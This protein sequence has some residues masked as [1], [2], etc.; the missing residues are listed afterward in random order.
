MLIRGESGTGK[1]LVAELIH[2]NSPRAAGPLVKV[3]CAALP[4]SLV[5]AELFGHERGAF[6]GALRA[7]RGASSSRTAARSSSTRSARCPLA[8]Q[9]KLLRV[10][11]E[12]E[13]ERVGG[14]ET[15]RVDVRLIAATNRDLERA[16]AEGTFREDLYYRLNVFTIC[17]P[18]LRERKPD[19]LLLA[20]HFVEKYAREHDKAVRRIST[21]AIDMLDELPLAGERARA[22]ELHRARGRPLRRRRPAQP[23][24]AA[25]AADARRAPG[26]VP[27][28]RCASPWPRWSAR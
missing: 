23:S 7:A 16:M 8:T 12:R 22:G 3:N 5:E 10:L 9:A 6:T 4:E 11:Q 28:A 1:E 26:T 24:P 27:P 20:D 2:R 15:L 13:F 25:Y 19:I 17:V 18:P 14:T 21:P